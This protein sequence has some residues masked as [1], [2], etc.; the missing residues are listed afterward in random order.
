ML[1]F[2][3]AED[4]FNLGDRL[5]DILAPTLVIAGERDRV[6]LPDVFRDTAAHVRNGQLTIYPR[7]GHS[8]TIAHRNLARDAIKFLTDY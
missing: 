3:R 1:A 4:A 5:N 7:A 2:I 6:Y 8:G